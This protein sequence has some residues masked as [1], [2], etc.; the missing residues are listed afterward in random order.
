MIW[1]INK[2]LLSHNE[3]TI[4]K[5]I[6]Q[7]TCD[8]IGAYYVKKKGFKYTPS[9]PKIVLEQGEYKLE[10]AFFSTRTN[11][12]G[13][14]VTLQ[15]IPTLY[16]K[17]SK[18]VKNSKGILTGYPDIF[19]HPT[20]EIPPKMTINHIYGEVEYNTESWITASVI[21]DYHACE[22][23][24]LTEE[25][26]HKIL[27][28]ID[29]K[30][31]DKFEALKTQSMMK[32][33][34][35]NLDLFSLEKTAFP[36]MV[37][38]KKFDTHL[39]MNLEDWFNNA[40]D[41]HDLQCFLQAI[42]EPYLYCAVPDFYNCP[43][44]KIDITKSHAA[45]VEAYTTNE[46]EEGKPTIG[47]RISPEGFWYG[48]SGDWAIVSDLVNN[49]FIVGLTHDA[50]LNFKADFP[51]KYFDAHKYLARELNMNAQLSNVI[52]TQDAE[53]KAWMDDFVKMYA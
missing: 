18:N 29:T 33:T 40:E 10:I 15:I 39:F 1:T 49:V 24:G 28:F 21:R 45:F 7:A 8:E 48:Q 36:R 38:K 53:V 14:S 31:I 37:F 5:D 34:L 17:S 44:F 4:C 42:N 26:F 35:F 6:F 2:T 43:D 23:Y 3:H 9:R 30:I 27:V 13:K 11:Q 19:Y 16:A 12:Q 46:K 41:Y 32:K 51:N 20:D 25:K 22:V 47:M 50:A 52:D